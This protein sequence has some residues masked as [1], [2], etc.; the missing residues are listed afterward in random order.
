ML[1]LDPTKKK[2]LMSRLMSTL[3]T[4]KV[5]SAWQDMLIF[6]MKTRKPRMMM[7]ASS[8]DLAMSMTSLLDHL[9]LSSFKK[10]RLNISTLHYTL[11]RSVSQKYTILLV[12]LL[13]TLADQ[14]QIC[15]ILPVKIS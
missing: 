13:L 4:I 6:L 14:M 3:S 5:V 9:I 1:S 7:V 10:N 8:I 2:V 12:M 11:K 15:S